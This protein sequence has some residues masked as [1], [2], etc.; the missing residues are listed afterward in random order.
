MESAE[1]DLPLNTTITFPTAST[2]VAAGVKTT[3]TT[4]ASIQLPSGDTIAIEPTDTGVSAHVPT[5]A[6]VADPA[7]QKSVTV[8]ADTSSA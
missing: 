5:G 6:V 2:P 7:E 1:A 8:P 4:H 3:A